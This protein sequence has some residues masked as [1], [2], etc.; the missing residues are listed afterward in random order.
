LQ[1][2]FESAHKKEIEVLIHVPEDLTIQADINM[3]GSTV[4]NLATNAVKF[5]PKNGK[6][7]ITAN[8]STDHSVLFSV[9]DSG[10][11]MNQTLLDKLFR[12]DEQTSRPG[13]D[14]ELST[15]LGLLLCKDFVEKQGGK[16]WVESEEGRGS[17]FFF[18][19]P[20]N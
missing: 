16:I 5:T 7:A 3:L 15:G 1:P 11:G 14:G 18:T 20:Q 12:L 6:I 19:I 2:V 13:T 10:I 17:T 4:R 9:S 8:L